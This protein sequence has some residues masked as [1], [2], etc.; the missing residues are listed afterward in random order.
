MMKR[1]TFVAAAA[2]LSLFVMHKSANAQS[3]RAPEPSPTPASRGSQATAGAKDLEPVKLILSQGFESF[4]KD[5]N[6]HGRQGYRLEKSLNYGGAGAS[7]SYAAVLRLD[8][9]NTYEYDWMSSPNRSLLDAR[10]NQQAAGGFRLVN[11]FAITLCDDEPEDPE[12]PTA[13]TLKQFR[14][15]KGDAFLLER[16][17]GAA[18]RTKEYKVFTAKVGPRKNPKETIQAALDAAPR[19]F[20]PVKILFAKEGWLDF[21]VSVLLERDLSDD[22]APKIEYRFVKEVSGFDKEVNA[23]AAEGFRLVAG[24]RVGLTKFALLA[25]QAAEPTAYTFVE[26]E[27]HAKEFDRT[28]ALGNRYEGVMAGDLTCDASEVVNQ[29][30]VFAREAGPAQRRYKVLQ[31]FNR[32]TGGPPAAALAEFRRLVGEDYRVVDLFY[33]DGLNVV[34][35]K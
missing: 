29:K 6:E 33:A 32:K 7:Q 31:V 8:A 3:G 2:L 16:R 34:F 15:L 19:G 10:L 23:L 1:R 14:F 28:A 13:R 18:A 26:D 35:E 24:R 25:K 21:R 5:L 17:N 4:V 27:K 22:A 9:G 30:L 11:A 20:R 12:D